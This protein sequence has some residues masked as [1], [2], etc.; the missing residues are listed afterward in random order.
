MKP[1]KQTQL[2]G[3]PRYS[4]TNV[5]NEKQPI[6]RE[7]ANPYILIDFSFLNFNDEVMQI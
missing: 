2:Y 5:S 1:H 7:V 6:E 3:F 4:I